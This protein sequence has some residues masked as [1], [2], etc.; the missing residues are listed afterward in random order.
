[1]S[2]IYF[3]K[4]W[5]CFSG[6]TGWSKCRVIIGA[7]ACFTQEVHSL[8]LIVF[9]ATLSVP[10][11]VKPL[12]W[13]H[14]KRKDSLKTLLHCVKHYEPFETLTY[15]FFHDLF[16]LYKPQ[17]ICH[18]SSTDLNLSQSTANCT[19]F[20]TRARK[21]KRVCWVIIYITSAGT[22]PVVYICWAGSQEKELE[23]RILCFV[24]ITCKAFDFY[25]A[26]SNALYF[27]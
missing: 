25:V 1:M 23:I 10:V 2:T 6:S 13:T 22:W 15:F 27:L 11:Q 7:H 12:A 26:K 20:G 4:T 9:K 5:L 3:M 21:K 17:N 18:S 16:F 8:F 14:D 24:R 19:C